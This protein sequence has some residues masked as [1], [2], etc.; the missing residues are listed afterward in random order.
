MYCIN[1]GGPSNV[2]GTGVVREI[3]F[4][5]LICD[6]LPDSVSWQGQTFP[7]SPDIKAMVDKD[8]IWSNNAEN[9]SFGINIVKAGTWTAKV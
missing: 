3:T 4:T 1:Y 9:G 8:G 6:A 7:I 5:A 2:S